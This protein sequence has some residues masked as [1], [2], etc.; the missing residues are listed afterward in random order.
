[1][2]AIIKVILS[3]GGFLLKL[4]S[5]IK[6]KKKSVLDQLVKDTLK[7]LKPLDEDYKDAVQEIIN[8]VHKHTNPTEPHR[9]RDDI[10]RKRFIA[11]AKLG[12]AVLR[13]FGYGGPNKPGS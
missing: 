9:L 10:Q 6:P 13:H 1:M 8:A 7:K 4:L 12:F 11:A 3:I 2:S 5:F